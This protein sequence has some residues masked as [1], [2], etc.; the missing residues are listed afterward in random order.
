MS[1]PEILLLELQ[2]LWY[3]GVYFISL[4]WNNTKT[5]QKRKNEVDIIP[6][7]STIYTYYK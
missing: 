7:R 5:E 4:H 3:L 6:Q 1:W 2:M